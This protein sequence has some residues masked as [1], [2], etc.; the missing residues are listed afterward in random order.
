METDLSVK[1]IFA[2]CFMTLYTALQ[3]ETFKG[4][5]ATEKA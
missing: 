5:M 2:K 1:A 4:L 3:K